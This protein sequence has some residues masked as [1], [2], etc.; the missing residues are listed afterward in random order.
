MNRFDVLLH[1]A[2]HV[3]D[4]LQKTTP[5][6]EFDALGLARWIGSGIHAQ[7]VVSV[8]DRIRLK[9]AKWSRIWD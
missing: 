6:G 4:V 2:Q 7:P 3:D 9:C 8:V 1:Q 5:F